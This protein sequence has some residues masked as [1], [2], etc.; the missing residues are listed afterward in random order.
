M[1]SIPEISIPEIFCILLNSHRLCH[2][3][4]Q[5]LP[6]QH[7]IILKMEWAEHRQQSNITNVLSIF[8]CRSNNKPKYRQAFCYKLVTCPNYGNSHLER[9]SGR[10]GLLNVPSFVLVKSTLWEAKLSPLQRNEM[11]PVAKGS[12]P[13]TFLLVFHQKTFCVQD[14]LGVVTSTDGIPWNGFFP[15]VPLFL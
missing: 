10:K 11:K 4:G 8:E 3:E 1:L 5:L 15:A 9:W 14:P 6:Y 2:F 13:N 7:T 12:L